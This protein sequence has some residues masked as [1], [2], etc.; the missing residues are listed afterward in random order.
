MQYNYIIN[1][2]II[3]TTKGYLN[4]YVGLLKWKK[5]N[6]TRIHVGYGKGWWWW[7]WRVMGA[8]DMSYKIGGTIFGTF[9]TLDLHMFPWY[10]GCW[11]L[12]RGHLFTWV[13]SFLIET[14]GS[15][16]IDRMWIDWPHCLYFFL[17]LVPVNINGWQ[18]TS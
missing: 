1:T 2:L 10:K 9:L 16:N 18:P 6:Q 13:R 7:W 17:S 11:R 14:I 3:L 15:L 8:C 12:R 5:S 4:R